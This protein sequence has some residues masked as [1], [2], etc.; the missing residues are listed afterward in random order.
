M[1]WRNRCFRKKNL[2]WGNFSPISTFHKTAG[3]KAF[4]RLKC[5]QKYL[6]LTRHNSN[7]AYPHSYNRKNNIE[8]NSNP[9][10]NY[11]TPNPVHLIL[12]KCVALS[13]PFT[14]HFIVRWCHLVVLKMNHITSISK[15][16]LQ[17]IT[18]QQHYNDMML[19]SS[20]VERD[21]SVWNIVKW[22]FVCVLG[23]ER[24]ANYGPN[25]NKRNI[26]IYD[27]S[28]LSI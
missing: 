4:L 28:N 15:L 10:N 21:S 19:F 18:R 27:Y 20:S 2:I 22:C 9:D 14:E 12:E 24:G 11:C 17:E 23:V 7:D 1:T 6:V 3:P 25:L 26:F 5:C 16:R 8:H 13:N